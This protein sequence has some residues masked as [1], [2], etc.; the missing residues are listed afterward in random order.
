MIGVIWILKLLLCLW[1]YTF[2]EII[3]VYMGVVKNNNERLPNGNIKTHL[4][5]R[6]LDLV[7]PLLKCSSKETI[8]KESTFFINIL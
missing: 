7:T 1:K 5:G 6:K 3:S 4:Q 8:Q 2:G